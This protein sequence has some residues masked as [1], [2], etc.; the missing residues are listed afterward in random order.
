MQIQ[1]EGWGI[2]TY[3]GKGKLEEKQKQRKPNPKIIDKQ[4]GKAKEVRKQQQ[5]HNMEG[6]KQIE[7]AQQK[8]EMW[9]RQRKKN[10]KQH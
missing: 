1:N 3:K 4:K 8:D 5:Q 6:N 2:Q 10:H 7:P 9:K